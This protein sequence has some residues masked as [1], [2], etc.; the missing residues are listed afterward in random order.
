MG[1]GR[2]HRHPGGADTNTEMTGKGGAH[3]DTTKELYVN[4][5]IEATATLE[6]G[7]GPIP[8]TCLESPPS[9]TL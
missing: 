3:T 8:S 6:V 2:D 1:C 7:G 4:G 5:D 9:A